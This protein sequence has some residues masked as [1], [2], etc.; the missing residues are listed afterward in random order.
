MT[1]PRLTDERLR[2]GLDSNQEDRERLCAALLSLDRRFSEIKPR[3]PR[4][5]PDQGRDPEALFENRLLAFGAVAFVNGAN[6]SDAQRRQVTKKFHADLRSALKHKPDL[7]LFVFFTNIDLAPTEIGVLEND[8]STKGNLAVEIFCRE[9]MRLALDTASGFAFRHQYL[10]IKMSDEEQATFSTEFGDDLHRL[11]AR[12]FTDIDRSLERIEFFADRPSPLIWLQ[13]VITLDRPSEPCEL[14]PFRVLFEFRRRGT[15][16]HG[17][18]LSIAGEDTCMCGHG[19][20]KFGIRLYVGTRERPMYDLK[21]Y[22]DAQVVEH[23]FL[24]G[25]LEPS[26]TI[27]TLGSL[28]QHEIAIFMTE[29]LANRIRSIDLIANVWEVIEVQRRDIHI[30]SLDHPPWWPENPSWPDLGPT[31]KTLSWVELTHAT[32]LASPDY[33]PN[34][35]WLIDSYARTP[36]RLH[37]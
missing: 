28:D 9:R 10:G 23:I 33:L 16:F 31:A 25:E 35:Q 26:S 20:P 36:Q 7:G 2:F 3:R 18:Q 11:I 22:F 30:E 15:G 6:D 21:N 12:K 1:T 37:S 32:G 14:A 8:A 5:G 24:G 27:P 29:T 17:P 34:V 19:G 13:A 4:G